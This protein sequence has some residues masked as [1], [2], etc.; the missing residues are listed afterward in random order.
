MELQPGGDALRPL[1]AGQTLDGGEALLAGG[2]GF[3]VDL[4]FEG[5]HLMSRASLGAQAGMWDAAGIGQ[6]CAELS[7]SCLLL[8]SRLLGVGPWRQPRSTASPQ[9]HPFRQA[10]KGGRDVSAC[11]PPWWRE[12][13]GANFSPGGTGAP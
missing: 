2:W 9:G 7:I 3:L 1:L 6:S 5:L 4:P 11:L 13:T 8:G 12:G 10:S